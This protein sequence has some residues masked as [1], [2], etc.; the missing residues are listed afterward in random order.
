M[1]RRGSEC[2]SEKGGGMRFVEFEEPVHPSS[3]RSN[4]AEFV[5]FI[6][7]NPHHEP[8]TAA[9]SIRPTPTSYNPTM[10]MRLAAGG[11][12]SSRPAQ[13]CRFAPLWPAIKQR[14]HFTGLL[15]LS[16]AC[17]REEAP[18]A[19]PAFLGVSFRRLFLSF[20]REP[21]SA[22]ELKFPPFSFRIQGHVIEGIAATLRCSRFQVSGPS[23]PR[24]SA[25]STRSTPRSMRGS[26][27]S[28]SL[29]ET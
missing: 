3:V 27:K 25:H 29:L 8:N 14:Y 26:L 17:K 20:L 11:R 7:G 12:H 1:A 2:S 19:L 9:Q 4:E 23:M 5:A 16:P 21:P 13:R 18:K 24:S 22:T 6:V 15:S 28:N 10:R